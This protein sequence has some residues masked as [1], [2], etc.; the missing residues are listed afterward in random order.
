[1]QIKKNIGELKFEFLLYWIPLK[2]E[3]ILN[4]KSMLI[5]LFISE[6]T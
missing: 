5:F 2:F 4:V 1:M 3:Q 6:N